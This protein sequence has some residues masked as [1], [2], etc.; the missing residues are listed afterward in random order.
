MSASMR[1]GWRALAGGLLLRRI[2]CLC[3]VP[4]LA[5]EGDVIAVVYGCSIP[6][7]LR[8]PIE[9]GGYRLVGKCYVHGVM[10]G[11]ALAVDQGC[12]EADFMMV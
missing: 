5:R 12:V 4:G 6:L 1:C 11:E 3:L 9:G 10:D 2:G 8:R 7:L